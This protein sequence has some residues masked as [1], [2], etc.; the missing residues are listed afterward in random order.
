MLRHITRG[1]VRFFILYVAL[2]TGML[3]GMWFIDMRTSCAETITIKIL[4]PT[5]TTTT[6]TPLSEVLLCLNDG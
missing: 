3:I 2:S 1:T 4:P 6:T 5:S